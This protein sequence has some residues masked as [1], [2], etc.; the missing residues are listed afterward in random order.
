MYKHIIILTLLFPACA[1]ATG[2]NE[3][4]LKKLF[5]SPS[6]RQAIN[7]T[8]RGGSG[9]FSVTGPSSIQIDGIVSRSNGKSVVWVNGKSALSG[10]MVDGVKVNANAMNKN[11]KIPVQVD[12]RTVYIKPGETWSEETGVVENDY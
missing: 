1:N 12:G 7:A 5:T 6:E 10:S 11:N 4:L 8:R 3:Q 2:F 9:D